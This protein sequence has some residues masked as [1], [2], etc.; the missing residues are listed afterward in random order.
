MYYQDTVYWLYAILTLVC[1]YGFTFFTSWLIQTKFKATAVFWYVTILFGGLA[2]QNGFNMYARFLK[3]SDHDGAEALFMSHWWTCR[4]ILPAII[5]LVFVVHM[6][7]QRC[8]F[9]HGWAVA[10]DRRKGDRREET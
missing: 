6:T 7:I 2:I 8:K 5:L 9:M 4:L 3:F 1:V 10:H